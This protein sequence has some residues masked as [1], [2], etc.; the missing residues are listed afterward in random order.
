MTTMAVLYLKQLGLPL[1]ALSTTV[2]G[3][4][5]QLDQAAKFQVGVPVPDPLAVPAPGP[6]VPHPVTVEGGEL[7]MAQLEA[8][9]DD[10]LEVFQWRVVETTGPGTTVQRRLDRV[11][12]GRVIVTGTTSG[13][14]LLIDVPRL[15]SEADLD[16][17]VRNQA[18][19]QASG[20]IIFG[21]D[22]RKT[23]SAQVPD[24]GDYVVFVEGYPPAVPVRLSVTRGDTGGKG[25]EL[26]LEIPKL[27]DKLQLKY[28]VHYHPDTST[29]AD[30]S[31]TVNFPA[32]DSKT[33]KKVSVDNKALDV[34]VEGYP[35]A[36]VPAS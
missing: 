25:K 16:F 35:P 15:G 27:G 26:T 18:G 32:N 24:T 19:L 17:Q 8:E 9:F 34:I 22:N 20:R 14:E 28:E 3:D 36:T 31:G 21:S 30:L 1:G 2:P 23:A 29:P 7:A 10:P 4:P 33:T 13:T 6:L 12:T 11:G 5:P